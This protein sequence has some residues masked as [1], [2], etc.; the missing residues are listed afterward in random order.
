MKRVL[1]PSL[2]LVT[3]M[4]PLVM[5]QNQATP[6]DG[7]RG[8][9]DWKKDLTDKLLA[10]LSFTPVAELATTKATRNIRTTLDGIKDWDEMASV[11]N[12]YQ[13]LRNKADSD[14][15]SLNDPTTKPVIVQVCPPVSTKRT[16]KL[17]PIIYASVPGYCLRYYGGVPTSYFDQNNYY[18]GP[19]SSAT[20]E[21]SKIVEYV[22]IYSYRVPPVFWDFNKRIVAKPTTTPGKQPTPTSKPL[23]KTDLGSFQH[24]PQRSSP[25]SVP[26]K[27]GFW[28]PHMQT[29]S[30]SPSGRQR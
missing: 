1:L 24:L 6:V 3:L 22:G 29:P 16:L 20:V 12:Y 30:A 19:M 4:V 26:A 10:D 17:S 14:I 18:V 27:G 8:L 11:Y 21:Y 23:A 25:P 2:F 28:V 13:T 7:Q 5:G 15:A 9:A